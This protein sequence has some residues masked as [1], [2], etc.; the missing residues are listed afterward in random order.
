MFTITNS[1]SYPVWPG[2]LSNAGTPPPPTTGFALSPGQSLPVPLAAGWS[3]RLWARTLCAYNNSSFS[4]VTG[5]CGT[6]TL[7]CSGHGAAPPA[8]LAEF[9]LSSNTGAGAGGLDFYD[10]S[11]VDGYN[12]PVLVAPRGNASCR[13]TGCPA[14]VNAACPRELSVSVAGGG[15][16]P[17]GAARGVVACRSACGAFG[18]AEYCCSGPDHGTPNTCAPTAY[19]KFF[20]AE[21]PEAYSY[22]YDDASSTFTCAGNGNGGGY[23]VVFCP[24]ESS[25]GKASPPA[26]AAAAYPPM[27]FSSGGANPAT[28]TSHA[29]IAVLLLLFIINLGL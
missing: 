3:G 14:D 15:V 10:V 13:A 25:G 28:T 16:G 18:T 9:T 1:C 24:G 17:S 5:D 29:V 27:A 21:C 8:T 26:S 7:E 23:D 12:V 22:A 20:K 2:I 11:L 6:G 4:C 19:S